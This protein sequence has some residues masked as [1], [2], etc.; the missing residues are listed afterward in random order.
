MKY[1]RFTVVGIL[2]LLVSATAR[3]QQIQDENP[4]SW[5]PVVTNTVAAWDNATD[6]ADVQPDLV[7]SQCPCCHCFPCQ[8]PQT[9]APCQPCPHVSTI[10]PYWNVNIFGALQADMIFNTAR[11]VAPGIPMFLFPGV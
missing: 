11:P 3:S 1:V 5:R 7:S 2:A 8:C 4:N 9:P 10:S 6:S